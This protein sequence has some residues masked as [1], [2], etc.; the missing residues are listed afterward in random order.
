MG[1]RRFR[2]GDARTRHAGITHRRLIVVGAACAT[3]ALAGCGSSGG[4]ITTTFTT[5]GSKA[6]AALGRGTP[7]TGFKATGSKLPATATLAALPAAQKGVITQIQGVAGQPLSQQITTIDGDINSF[8]GGLFNKAKLQWPAM[9]QSLI[10]TGTASAPNCQGDTTIAATDPW[11]L[12][13]TPSGG[14]FYFPL[15][16]VAQNVATDQSGVNLLLGMAEMWSN[17]VENLLGVTQAAQNG[18]IQPADYAEINVCLAG[19]Y[20]YSVNDRQ[21]FQTGDQQTFQNWYQ[22][23]SPEFTDVSAKDVSTQQLQQAFAAGLKSGNPGTCLPSSGGG[24]GGGGGGTTSQTATQTQS[25]TATQPPST[26]TQPAGGGR[27]TGTIPLGGLSTSG[28]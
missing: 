6:A 1:L 5:T 2:S 7:I 22:R 27:G 17:H 9:R 13:D 21:L 16:W 19:V 3:L 26:Q 11:R 23:M 28:G 18:Q 8:W 15:P 12:C 25:Q 20:A 10:S 4:Q 14:T 24:G